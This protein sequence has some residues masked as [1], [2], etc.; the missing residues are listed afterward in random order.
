MAR[1]AGS[2]LSSA[3]MT[4]TSMPGC[5]DLTNWSSSMPSDWGKMRSVTTRSNFWLASAVRASAVDET[6]TTW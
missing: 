5:V 2:T 4:S 3:V 6:G 1:T